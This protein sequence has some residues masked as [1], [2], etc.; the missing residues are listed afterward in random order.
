MTDHT[1]T[2]SPSPSQPS[3]EFV[4]FL[5]AVRDLPPQA[6]TACPGWT[7]H[8]LLAHVVAGAQEIARLVEEAVA[9]GPVS[10]TRAFEEREAPLRAVA[11]PELRNLLFTEGAR[12]QSGLEALH[13]AD[14]SRTVPFTG[15]AM[16]VD[17]V[18][19]HLRSELALHRWDLVGDDDAGRALLAQPDLFAHA[20]DVRRHMLALAEVARSLPEQ[21][22]LLPAA[23]RLL[24]VWGRRPAGEDHGPDSRRGLHGMPRML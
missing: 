12:L 22:D 11:D 24:A 9:G 6:P 8:D 4:A 23:D 17:Q 18:R 10:G 15:W 3:A 2:S 5:T 7:V 21:L 14:P 19:T 20:L 1:A 13:A 16:T